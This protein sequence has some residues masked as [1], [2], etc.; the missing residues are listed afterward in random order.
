ME[1][2]ESIHKVI[3]GFLVVSRPTVSSVV[4]NLSAPPANIESS[5]GLGSSCIIVAYS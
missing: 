2:L 4:N 5:E 3:V 1:T